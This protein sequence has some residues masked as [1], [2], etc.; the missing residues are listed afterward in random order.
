MSKIKFHI[1]S[2]TEL[3][4]DQTA[5]LGDV[6]DLTDEQNIDTSVINGKIAEILDEKLA[7]AKED[8]ESQQDKQ[9]KAELANQLQ[10]QKQQFQENINDKAT[11]IVELET[12]LKSIAQ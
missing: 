11:R 6:V 3:V 10:Q 7:Q 8:W 4:L 12:Q 9:T 5:Q 2:Q 1:A